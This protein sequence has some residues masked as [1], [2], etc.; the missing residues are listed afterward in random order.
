MKIRFLSLSE[1][2]LIHENQIN[3]YG[4]NP[5]IR[6]IN[7]LNSAIGMPESQFSNQFLHS[8]IYEMASAY[9]FHIA[10]NHPFVDGNKRTA[11]VSGLVF[12]D[13]NKIEINDPNELLYDMLIKVAS[14]KLNK[15]EITN[16]L[17]NLSK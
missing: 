9:I 1:I 7:L 11:L 3:N 6:D 4:G 2:I 12:L 8:D 17:K 5:G 16:I 15:K 13:L 14:G 10:Q